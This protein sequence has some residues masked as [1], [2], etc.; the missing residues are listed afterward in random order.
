M[1]D[2]LEQVIAKQ[3]AEKKA[4]REKLASMTIESLLEEESDFLT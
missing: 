2:V 4:K 3:A 1:K